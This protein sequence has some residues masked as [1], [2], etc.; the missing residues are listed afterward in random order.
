VFSLEVA[1]D[2]SAEVYI[3]GQ[4]VDKDEEDHEFAYWNRTVPAPAKLLRPGRNVVAVLV[5]NSSGS[6]DL[7][8]DLALTARVPKK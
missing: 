7:Y 2:N 5:H 6:S 8:F 4:L 3:N 1:S